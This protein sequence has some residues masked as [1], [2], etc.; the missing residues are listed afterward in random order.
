[1][2]IAMELASSESNVETA[3]SDPAQG[4]GAMMKH[5]A[6]RKQTQQTIFIT[7]PPLWNNGVFSL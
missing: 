6:E 5:S 2:A 3:A 7:S 4:P 1:M